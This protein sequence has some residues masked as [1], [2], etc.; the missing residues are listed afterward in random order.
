M[1]IEN[2]KK[3]LII[4]VSGLVGSNIYQ[5]LCHS[6]PQWEVTG[7]YLH[8]QPAFCKAIPLSLHTS[9]K[10]FSLL[11]QRWDTVIHTGAMTHVDL[12]EQQPEESYLQTVGSTKMLS[13][14]LP[15]YTPFIYISTDYVFD[16]L[17]G[18]Y[19]ENDT[20]SPINIYGKHKLMAEEIVQQ[21][22][23]HPIILRVANV[24]GNEERNKNFLARILYQIAEKKAIHM[25]IAVDQFG[26]PVHAMDIA[27]AIEI[28]ITSNKE[29]IYH[30]GGLEYL[31]RYQWIKRVSDYFPQH[32]FTYELMSSEELHQ[33]AKRP[34]LAG[35]INKKIYSLCP[36]FI[37]SNID[38][39]LQSFKK[40]IE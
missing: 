19:H 40:Q 34:L 29:G 35:L 22:F 5:H 17:K 28:I 21:H 32:P 2:K 23:S 12:C 10:D 14:Y 15:S 36:H 37:M 6:Q 30:L 13:R 31:N 33:P 20:P 38:Q 3:I 11:Q 27:K 9:N 39:Y 1:T 18:P 26:S 7:T 8:H 24:Y 16:G 25:K 4:G